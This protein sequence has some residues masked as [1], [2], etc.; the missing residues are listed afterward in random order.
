MDHETF[1]AEPDQLL[2]LLVQPHWKEP[3][4]AN[5]GDVLL[6]AQGCEIADVVEHIPV[7]GAVNTWANYMRPRSDKLKVGAIFCPFCH[8][9]LAPFSTKTPR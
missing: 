3:R 5:P 4:P 2:T 9:H 1:D 8:G 7:G 6:C